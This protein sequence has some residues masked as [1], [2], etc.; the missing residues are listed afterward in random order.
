MLIFY[1]DRIWYT[2]LMSEK[3]TPVDQAPTPQEELFTYIQSKAGLHGSFDLQV[4]VGIPDT[5]TF[6]ESA[7]YGAELVDLG[8]GKTLVVAA[9]DEAG[10]IQ[11]YALVE[12]STDL[13]QHLGT[14]TYHQI[15][16]PGFSK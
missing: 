16:I 13:F 9:A 1:F 14:G 11:K 4:Q 15:V 6:Q 10:K 2:V 8:E 3:P 12:G 5:E 7:L